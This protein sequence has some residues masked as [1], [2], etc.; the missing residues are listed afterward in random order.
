MIYITQDKRY[1]EIYN[2]KEYC[3]NPIFKGINKFDSYYIIVN[4]FNYIL[5]NNNY[6]LIDG[7]R[8]RIINQE[9]LKQYIPVEVLIISKIA[10]LDTIQKLAVTLR[11]SESFVWSLLR[12]Q[13]SIEIEHLLLLCVKYK[14][15][16]TYFLEL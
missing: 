7:E 12:G 2:Y 4:N 8:L 6:L 3:Q 15:E 13:V 11:Q 5:H 9:M 10:Q 16:I 1:V 14:K